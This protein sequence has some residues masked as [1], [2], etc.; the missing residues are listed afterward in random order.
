VIVD[1]GEIVDHHYLSSP[2]SLLVLYKV[3]SE[4]FKVFASTFV[5]SSVIKM[6]PSLQNVFQNGDREV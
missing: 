1:I 6:P 3:A 2:L 5:H 4:K